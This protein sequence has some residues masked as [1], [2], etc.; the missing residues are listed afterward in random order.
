VSPSTTLVTT[1]VCADGTVGLFSG[2]R[3]PEGFSDRSF[4]MLLSFDGPPLSRR[5]AGSEEETPGGAWAR[6][7]HAAR[8]HKTEQTAS[9]P[10]T[11]V[12]AILF[13]RRSSR[14]G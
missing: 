11:S 1:A 10:V 13:Y 2:A 12:G 14:R 9:L 5:S 7:P 3:P 6:A 8:K 4:C